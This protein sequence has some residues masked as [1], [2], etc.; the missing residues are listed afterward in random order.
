MS[1]TSSNLSYVTQSA[2]KPKKSQLDVIREHHTN[3]EEENDE[4]EENK[5]DANKTS[6]LRIKNNEVEEEGN[7]DGKSIGERAKS[8]SY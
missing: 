6:K 1:E 7:N 8:G 2:F 3:N 4:D 5:D